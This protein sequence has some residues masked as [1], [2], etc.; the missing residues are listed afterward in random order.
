MKAMT[1]GKGKIPAR[2]MI[3]DILGGMPE[4]SVMEKYQ[5][6][7]SSLK[8]L[9]GRLVDRGLVEPIEILKRMNGLDSP[10]DTLPETVFIFL[11]LKAWG[12][13]VSKVIVTGQRRCP[14][15]DNRAGFFSGAS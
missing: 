8:V 1:E 3:R 2:E 6:S 11:G 15:S 5:L 13:P 14:Q 7:S 10:R 4:A 9:L 12:F